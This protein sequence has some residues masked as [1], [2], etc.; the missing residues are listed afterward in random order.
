MKS[1]KD[2]EVWKVSMNMVKEVYMRT[3]NFPKTE[4]FCL[5][6]QIRRAAVS[7]PANI[8]E[9][10]ARKNTKEF[11]HFLRISYGSL[12]ELETLLL[13]AIN[14]EYLSQENFKILFGMIKIITVQLRT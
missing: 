8:S 3:N 1:Q 10:S 6:T 2:L 9:G 7:V 12:A 5:T 13:L 14:L 4:I 11:R